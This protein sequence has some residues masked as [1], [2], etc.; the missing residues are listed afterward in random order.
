MCD[1]THACFRFVL[2]FVSF[3]HEKN[4]NVG[5]K[6]IT[7]AEILTCCSIYLIILPMSFSLSLVLQQDRMCL[8]AFKDLF[9]RW[10][11]PFSLC[12][13]FP[14]V[15]FR[16]ASVM[17]SCTP[18]LLIVLMLIYKQLINE[19]TCAGAPSTWSCSSFA[20]TQCTAV[21]CALSVHECGFSRT[22]WSCFKK[23]DVT[24]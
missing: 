2:L 12:W 7:K 4:K 6:T 11:C 16:W 20:N 24:V 9:H 15:C 10:P 3:L 21:Q 5:V 14:P 13:A 19:L 8:L 17:C 1:G 23:R 22:M 18:A